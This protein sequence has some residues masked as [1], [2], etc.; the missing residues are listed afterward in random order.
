M[1]V[2]YRKGTFKSK[3]AEREST[4][5]GHFPPSSSVTGVKCFSAAAMTILATRGLPKHSKY[6][7]L[8]NLNSQ[9]TES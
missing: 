2:I 6:S 1:K 4:I 8:N 7:R 5:V 3:G 9:L